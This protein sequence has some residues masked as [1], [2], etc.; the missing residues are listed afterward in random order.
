MRAQEAQVLP[1]ES[2]HFPKALTASR[3]LGHLTAEV[4]PSCHGRDAPQVKCMV[5]LDLEITPEYGSPG[6]I[7]ADDAA[8]VGAEEKVQNVNFKLPPISSGHAHIK[9]LYSSPP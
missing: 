6:G 3:E 4:T 9:A 7:M 1:K 2:G 8:A 5:R